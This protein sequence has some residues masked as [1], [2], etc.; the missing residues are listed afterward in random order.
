M[1]AFPK[2]TLLDRSIPK[3]KFYLNLKA[4]SSLERLFIDEVKSIRW[5][6]KLAPDTFNIRE[7]ET[8]KEIEVL[9]LS[10][11][12]TTISQEIVE[13]IDREI[14]YHLVF[15]MRYLDKGQIWISYKQDSKKKAGTFKVERY[16]TTDWI[17]YDDL[18]LP[19]DGL[20]M[21]RLYESF[22]LQVAGDR[23]QREAG[24]DIQEAVEKDIQREKLERRIQKLE[25]KIRNE[26]QFNRQV[27]LMAELREAQAQLE[28]GFK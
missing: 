15:V 20:T 27:G 11:K 10:L 13:A 7:G 26:R 12:G 16:Y 25:N 5:M 1:L 6:Y 19:F 23:L 17:P 4:S 2:S 22:L 18:T 3:Q 8:V 14:P 9:E 28:K 24:D 21:D